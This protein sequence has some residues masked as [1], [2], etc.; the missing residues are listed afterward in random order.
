MA[1]PVKLNFKIYQGSTFRE[2]LRWE[3]STKTYV[4]ITNITKTAPVVVTATAHGAPLGWRARVTGVGGMK[5][6]NDSENYRVITATTTNT[7]TFNAI[8]ATGYTAYTSGGI[9]EYN[10]PVDLAGYTARMQIRSQLTS[11]STLLELTT[12][13]GGVVLDNSAK[14]ITILITASQTTALTFSTAVYSL[15]LVAGTEVVPF[16]GGTV[17]LI[18]EVT[19]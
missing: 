9:L 15:E 8:N 5:E 4:P 13:N 1:A 7:V 6:I 10:T 12:A 19:R 14:T 3:S 16:C 18:P 17:T 11:T 2:V